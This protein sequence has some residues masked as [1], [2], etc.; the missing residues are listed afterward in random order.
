MSVNPVNNQYYGSEKKEMEKMIKEILKFEKN[1]IKEMKKAEKA[2]EKPKYLELDRKYI[3]IM[4]ERNNQLNIAYSIYNDAKIAYESIKNSYRFKMD[5]A[6]QN[7][8]K[9][10]LDSKQTHHS[11]SEAR[12]IVKNAREAFY[13]LD[14]TIYPD[15]NKATKDLK[16]TEREYNRCYFRILLLNKQSSIK[17]NERNNEYN[18]LLKNAICKRVLFEISKKTNIDC[19]NVVLSFLY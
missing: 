3:P 9:A 18:R 7:L 5:A 10:I 14:K 6:R 19:A 1:D 2:I 13:S 8:E 4:T 12:I 17:Y 15:L 11:K 16:M